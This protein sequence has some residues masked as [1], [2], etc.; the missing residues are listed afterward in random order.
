[1]IRAT[2]FM[3]VFAVLVFAGYVSADETKGAI[4]SVDTGRNE[5]VLKGV[6]QN[7]IYELNKDAA[8]C[9]DGVKSKLAD[10]KEGDHAVVVY[11][12]KGDHLMASE[13]R[14]LRNA[15]EATG[16]V[17]G[18]F[19]DK[20]EI[21]LKGVVKDTTYELNRDGTVWLN[22]NESRL[23]D[24]REGDQVT[25]TYQKKG[26]HHMAVRVRAARK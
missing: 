7:S 18:I 24:L 15:Q 20:K 14:G 1:M 21:T 11:E 25:I 23:A 19:A 5:V 9:L 13:V 8:V 22:G 26:D 17:R 12:K 10:L 6:V 3:S 4:K 2:K 16:T